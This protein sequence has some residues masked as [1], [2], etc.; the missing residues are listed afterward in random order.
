MRK[1]EFSIAGKAYMAHL[2]FCLEFQRSGAAAVTV[3]TERV[4]VRKLN[5]GA[6]KQVTHQILPMVLVSP[7]LLGLMRL[8]ISMHKPNMRMHELMTSWRMLFRAA[9]V[10]DANSLANPTIQGHERQNQDRVR[11]KFHG[12]VNIVK[13]LNMNSKFPL[14]V[15][16]LQKRDPM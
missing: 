4:G 11:P 2:F 15:S 6:G 1:D 9:L 7:G 16:V 12:R 3:T 10:Q 8:T 5:F 14:Y 13:S